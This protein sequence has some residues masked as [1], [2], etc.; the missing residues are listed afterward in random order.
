MTESETTPSKFMD[1]CAFAGLDL[2]FWIFR[3]V[4]KKPEDL[5]VF[6][7]YDTHFDEAQGKCVPRET[8]VCKAIDLTGI[9]D[10]AEKSNMC[11]AV[12]GCS[13]AT[14][15]TACEVTNRCTALDLGDGRPS[16]KEQCDANPNCTYDI[17]EP[18]PCYVANPGLDI[19]TTLYKGCGKEQEK[20]TVKDLCGPGTVYDEDA[21]QC[22][23]PGNN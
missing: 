9:T 2:G 10:N 6:C 3:D 1:Q 18:F 8:P 15:K 5:K 22:R 11:N 4:E 17:D 13:L 16:Q 14:N 23:L 7:G 21:K 20:F 12:A 19:E